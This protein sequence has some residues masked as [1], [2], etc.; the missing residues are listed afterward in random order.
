METVHSILQWFAG[1]SEHPYMLLYQC[2]K[3]DWFWIGLTVGLDLTVAAGYGVIA[4]HWWRNSKLLPDVPAKR[5]LSHM[6]NIFLFC[7]IC[8]YIFIPI[9]MFWPGWRLYDFFMMA[10]VYFTWRY[11]LRSRE[12]KVVYSELGNS[13]RLAEDLEKSREESKQ[14]GFFLNAVSHDMRTPLNGMVLQSSVAELSLDTNDVEAAKKAL[15]Q[16]RSSAT[17]ASQLLDTLLEYARLETPTEP[18]TDEFY[19]AEVLDQ[20]SQRCQAMAEEK[21]VALRI[22]ESNGLRLRTDRLKL[23]RILV[24]LVDNAIK[25]TGCASKLDGATKHDGQVRVEFQQAGQNIEIHVIDNGVGIDPSL[26][27]RLFEEFFQVQNH[28]RDRNKGFG[29]GLAIAQRLARQLGG[30]ISVDSAV[31][32]GSRFSVILSN[33]IADRPAPARALAGA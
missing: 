26:Q 13:T 33:V 15:A 14:K 28:E 31:G 24:N 8:G 16:I 18:C 11:A 4:M 20:L 12:L 1:G 22:A 29:M 19:L 7:G 5:A 3:R 27:H 32:R 23:D 10:L 2:M 9:K 6:R 25:F 17:A 30:D 21:R